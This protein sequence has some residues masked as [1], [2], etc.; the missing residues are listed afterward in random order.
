MG[1]GGLLKPPHHPVCTSPINLITMSDAGHLIWKW[2]YALFLSLVLFFS[3]FTTTTA[4]DAS[5]SAPTQCGPLHLAW[6]DSYI[7]FNIMVLPFD[8]RPI[9]IDGLGL[10]TA[11]HDKQAKTFNYTLNNLPLKSGTQFVVA[12]DY[13][14]GALLFSAPKHG[15]LT[16]Y[17][18]SGLCS[19]NSWRSW[20]CIRI[21][22][23]NS[24]R[25]VEFN[26]RFH[27]SSRADEFVLRAQPTHPVAMLEPDCVM[28][29]YKVPSATQGPS[30][31]PRWSEYRT[32]LSNHEHHRIPIMDHEYSRRNPGG[33]SPRTI[34]PEPGGRQF[35][36]EPTLYSHCQ[37]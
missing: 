14:F 2:S 8:A 37:Q 23:P 4:F 13:G 18:S 27:R 29:R 24:R 16:Q 15:L 1:S 17:H 31:D 19:Y 26:L 22:D 35:K 21:F 36:N 33:S 11:L 5:N 28:E 20:G 3:L 9:I 25:L 7:L 30:I 34:Q 32:R 12:A 6:D 10:I